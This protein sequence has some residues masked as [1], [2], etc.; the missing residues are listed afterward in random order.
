MEIDKDSTAWR[1]I[2]SMNGEVSLKEIVDVLEGLGVPPRH[3]Q[4]YIEAIKREGI[5]KPSEDDDGDIIYN[6][7]G[8]F[9]PDVV[10]REGDY[11]CNKCGQSLKNGYFLR[12]DKSEDGPYG[13]ECVRKIGIARL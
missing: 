3:T 13:P 5:G 4:D 9:D 7:Y 10:S 8:E 2:C 12:F 11:S 1:A 6:M